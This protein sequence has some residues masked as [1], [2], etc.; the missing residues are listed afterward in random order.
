MKYQIELDIDQDISLVY[1][2]YL[3]GN[4]MLKWIQ[5]LK[6]VKELKG[7]SFEKGS[8]SLLVFS[9]HDQIM[10]MKLTVQD[11]KPHILD[12]IYEVPGAWNRCVSTF[13]K[14]DGKTHWVMDVTFVFE[15]EIS[16]PIERFMDKTKEGMKLYKTYIENMKG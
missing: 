16:L 4:D 11:K 2:N 6:D 10:E 5:G 14:V 15:Q 8:E 9:T 13:K 7:S 12:V 3:N 1:E